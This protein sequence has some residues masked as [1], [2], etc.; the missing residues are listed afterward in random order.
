MSLSPSDFT[1]LFTDPRCALLGARPATVSVSPPVDLTLPTGQVVVCDPFT[2]LGPFAPRPFTAAV[3]PGG[4]P[5]TLAVASFDNGGTP[6]QVAAAAHLRT[7]AACP[8]GT[9]GAIAPRRVPTVW[10]SA[11]AGR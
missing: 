8:M 6:A 2:G 10:R 4:Y 7:D 5:V 3:R 1:A 9:T 11:R